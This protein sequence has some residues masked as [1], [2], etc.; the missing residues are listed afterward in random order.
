MREKP[1]VLIIDDLESNL[2]AVGNTLVSEGFDISLAYNGKKGIEIAKKVIPDLILL[3]L[4][5]PD[6]DG[7][8]VCNALK[9]DPTTKDIPVIFLTSMKNHENIIK[10]FEIGA[11]DYIIKPAHKKETLVRVKTH[12]ELKRT[13]EM[14]LEQ[15]EKLKL[16]IDEKNNFISLASREIMNPINDIK[17]INVFLTKLNSENLNNGD[18]YGYTKNIE[19]AIRG[20]TNIINDLLYLHEIEQDQIKSV[21][22]T[23]AVQHL[24][25]AIAKDFEKDLKAKRMAIE[26]ENSVD[27]NTYIYADKSKVEKIFYNLISN[28][29]KY[30]EFY[31]PIKIKS[32]VFESESKKYIL[33]EIRDQGVGMSEEDLKR[34]FQKFAKLSS[35]PTDNESSIGL[36][37][38]IV[39][40]L[41]DDMKGKIWFESVLKEG[42]TV[43][44][45]LPT[46]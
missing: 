14:L 15:N 30:S 31:K 46:L 42:T 38:P 8:D 28:A 27:R 32:S 37:L 44:V 40:K 11:V 29:I 6:V 1:L 25:G 17:A 33:I 43:R 18:I 7:Y 34:I 35:N 23:F 4:V 26:L 3:D 36:G 13:K 19:L 45:L 21:E 2:Q 10:G 39:K 22:D 9:A 41:I 5:M 16:L 24:V 12:L 20:V